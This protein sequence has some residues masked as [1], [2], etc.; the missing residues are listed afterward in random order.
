[1]PLL[2]QLNAHTWKIEKSGHMIV[3]GI[4]YGSAQMIT[5]MANDN[6]FEQVAA[7]A[8]LP[9]IVGNAIAMPDIHVGYGFPIGG[10]AAFDCNSGVICP[11]GVGYDIN[12]GVRLMCTNL[13]KSDIESQLSN[14]LDCIVMK[15]PSGMTRRTGECYLNNTQLNDV[16]CDGVK[17]AVNN[18]YGMHSDME[19]IESNGCMPCVD[20]DL[21]SPCAKK[22]GKSQLGSLGGGNHFIEIQVVDHIFDDLSAETMGLEPDGV[23]LMIHTGSRGLGHQ[24]CDDYMRMIAGIS[25]QYGIDTPNKELCAVPI[26]SDEGRAYLS[27][28]NGAANYAF[29]NRQVIAGMI[30]SAL[31]AVLHCSPRELGVQLIYD[32]THNMAKIEIHEVDGQKKKLCVHRKGATRAFP[33]TH[34]DIPLI[35]RNIGQPV[36]IPGSMGTCSYVMTGGRG[37]MVKSFG[38]SCHGAGRVLSRSQARKTILE[39]DVYAHLLQNNISIRCNSESS[40]SE[41]SPHAYKD[42]NDVVECIHALDI[43]KPV[44]RLKPLGVVKG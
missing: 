6:A 40:I 5:A 8:S 4:I 35:Y 17:W 1:M 10:V 37:S 38:S 28:M 30:E 14:V 39:K 2:Q 21:I 12:C 16:L 41:E 19:M 34:S 42:V 29:A 13:D 20:P 33:P 25:H 36:L 22:R 11:G 23:V 44:A 15:I 26:D 31:Q 3:P 43:A 9:G 32:I 27:A 24:V 7:M 18:G